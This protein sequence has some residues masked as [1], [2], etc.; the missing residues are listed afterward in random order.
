MWY[1]H[2]ITET[3]LIMV[4]GPLRCVTGTSSRH[5]CILTSRP[6]TIPS[7]GICRNTFALCS[8][9]LSCLRQKYVTTLRPEVE[10]SGEGSSFCSISVYQV[11]EFPGAMNLSI[12]NLVRRGLGWDPAVKSTYSL[13]TTDC[14]QY[15]QID[16]CLHRYA[17]WRGALYG[18]NSIALQ[19]RSLSCLSCNYTHLQ[20]KTKQ[21]RARSPDSYLDKHML[22]QAAK[23]KERAVSIILLSVVRQVHIF[24]WR[25]CK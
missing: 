16:F 10:S 20:I 9:T 19:Q 24:F 25:E 18:T 3:E 2:A 13:C 17:D 12:R 7:T 8:I 14:T 23:T 11:A 15:C 22:I 6:Q 1:R 5:T 21:P 4:A